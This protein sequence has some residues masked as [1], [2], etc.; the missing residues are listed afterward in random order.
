MNES[1]MYEMNLNTPK[2]RAYAQ[3]LRLR[4]AEGNGRWASAKLNR[5]VLVYR[6]RKNKKWN[7]PRDG[8]LEIDYRAG[9]QKPVNLKHGEEK[10]ASVHFKLNL[11]ICG[12]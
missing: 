12:I 6:P 2:N 10:F 7:V 8:L 1:Y 5:A 9:R 11:R 4:A 3:L